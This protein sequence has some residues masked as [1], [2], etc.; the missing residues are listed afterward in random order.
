MANSGEFATFHFQAAH[1]S[2]ENHFPAP[3][4]DF[5]FAAVV[6]IGERH[7]GYSHAVASA[8]RK[9][10]LPEN[11][12]AEAGVGAI[13]F[14]VKSAHEDHSP[15]TLDGTLRLA[16]ATEPFEHGDAALFLEIGGIPLGLQDVE[17]GARDGK[18][19]EKRKRRK[20]GKRTGQ[21][22]WRGQEP[23]LHLSPAALRVE[24]EEPVEKLDFAGG[25]DTAVEILKI[26]AATKG[27][28][29]AIVHVLAVGQHVG[30]R[31]AAEEG[32]LFKQPYAPAGFSQR[33][34]G[35]QPRQPAADH[36][37][38]FQECSLPWCARNA[39]WR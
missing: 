4:L 32:T 13:Q 12:N 29:L 26:G 1:R 28:M 3:A 10:N 14:F 18:L 21:M 2:A 38:A 19:V 7:G 20:G 11:I 17:H 39:P 33:D 37:H 25:A 35:R 23:G 27:H 9:K 8:V 6:Q 15:E 24:K 5:G 22:K 34:A 30:G 31:P 36:D 16:A